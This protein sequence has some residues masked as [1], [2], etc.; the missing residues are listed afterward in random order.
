MFVRVREDGATVADVGNLRALHV[1]LTGV[2]TTT[3]ERAITAAGLGT[4]D[5]DHVWLEIAALRAAGHPTEDWRAGF[6]RMIA[7]AAEQGWVDGTRVRAHV[8]RS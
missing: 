4:P 5:G 1:D 2:D 3:A 7:Y 8:V 6:D